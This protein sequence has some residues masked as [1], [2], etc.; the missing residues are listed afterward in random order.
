MF[1]SPP[2]P[3]PAVPPNIPLSAPLTACEAME[4]RT[5]SATRRKSSKPRLPRRIAPSSPR[6]STLPALEN[7]SIN[8][9]ST[10]PRIAAISLEN[11]CVLARTSTSSVSTVSVT[12]V[13]LHPCLARSG[14]PTRPWSSMHSRRHRRRAQGW[15]RVRPGC[16]ARTH[17]AAT[18]A[19]V[20]PRPQA[21]PRPGQSDQSS[22][23]L[24]DLREQRAQRPGAGSKSLGSCSFAHCVPG[25]LV[26][27]GQAMPK[28]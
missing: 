21:G 9:P 24:Q 27:I 2:A 28:Q 6:S 3:L 8:V 11:P 17:P 15:P 23:A 19:V 22:G 12:V 25:Q 10:A 13:F 14:W 26:A 16:T 4:S 18:P 5:L 7:P 20:Q 1:S